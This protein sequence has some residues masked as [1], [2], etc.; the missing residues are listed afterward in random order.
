MTVRTYI[1][2]FVIAAVIAALVTPVI[3]AMA[4]RFSIVDRPDRR[5][6]HTTAIPRL[7]GIGIALAFYTPILGLYL[8]DR[9]FWDNTI[10]RAVFADFRLIFAVVAGGGTMLVLGFVDDIRGVRALAK[11]VVQCAVAMLLYFMGLQITAVALPFIGQVQMG[12]LA[13]PLTVLWIVGI[14]NAINLIDG[15]DG[16]AAGVAFFVC[17]TNFVVGFLGENILV[18]LLNASLAGALIGFLLWNFN[19]ARI[20]MGDSGSLF[21]GLVIAVTSLVGNKQKGS[22]AIALLV[23]IVALGVPI[24]DTLLTMVRRAIERRP[25]FSADRG[26]IHHKLLEMGLTHRRAVLILYSLTVLLTLSAIAIYLGRGW[27]TGGALAIAMVVLFGMIRTMGLHRAIPT[28]HGRAVGFPE[29]V[30]AM[31]AH[32][33]PAMRAL[34][35]ASSLAEAESRLAD[36]VREAGAESVTFTMQDERC[37]YRFDWPPPDDEGESRS[38]P[39]STVVKEDRPGIPGPG[40][41]IEW[42][43]SRQPLSLHGKVLLRL[44]GEVFSERVIALSADQRR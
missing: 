11:L 43:D 41:A 37:P 36:F 18:C 32:V 33:A 29:Q 9:H 34:D 40:F 28:R 42:R 14:V 17:T 30:E 1:A 7:G 38:E 2:A 23:P 16:L 44:V 26:H 5:R 15:L 3:R 31:V 21:L 6:P 22:T 12:I 4:L 13:L 25:I 8:W 20:F 27:Q 24:M 35:Q 39:T 10:S 19:P